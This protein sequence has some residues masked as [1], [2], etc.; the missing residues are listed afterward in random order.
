MLYDGG[1][2][3]LE[4]YVGGVT[5]F[6][7]DRQYRKIH[8]ILLKGWNPQKSC[9]EATICP[10]Y[11]TRR[12]YQPPPPKPATRA[13]RCQNLQK[14]PPLSHFTPPPQHKNNGN[15]TPPRALRSPA[16]ARLQHRRLARTVRSPPPR[17]RTPADAALEPLETLS[18]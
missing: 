16:R 5:S 3:L 2:N 9:R 4:R 7:G 17:V 10:R 1:I 14:V 18:R 8:K 12:A 11:T 15:P 13:S 6:S